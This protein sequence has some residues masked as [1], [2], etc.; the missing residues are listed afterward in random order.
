MTK[1]DDRLPLTPLVLTEGERHAEY[2][3]RRDEFVY[4]PFTS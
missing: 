4:T 3:R 2:K 1:G